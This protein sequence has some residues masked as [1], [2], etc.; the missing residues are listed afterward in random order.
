[1][2][3]QCDGMAKSI[4]ANPASEPTTQGSADHFAIKIN[5]YYFVHGMQVIFRAFQNRFGRFDKAIRDD[6]NTK[7]TT[8]GVMTL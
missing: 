2:R 4:A 5:N 8:V 6:N 7:M 3:L 1:M